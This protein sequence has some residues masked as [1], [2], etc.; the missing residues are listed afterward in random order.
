MRRVDAGDHPLSECMTAM[1]IKQA[2]LKSPDGKARP[3]FHRDTVA[4]Q[5][6]MKQIF[7]NQDYSLARL[8]RGAELQQIGRSLARPLI[9]DAGANI[10]ASVCWFAFHF[11]HAHIV[12]VEPDPAN[13]DLLRRNTEGLN[14]TPHQAALGCED[15]RV[16][17]VDPGAGEWGYRTVQASDGA[18]PL[19]AIG[20]L[21]AEQAA[22][23][24]HPF[25][26][27]V[28]IEGGE[29][30]LFAPPVDWVDRFPLIVVELHDWLMPGQGTSRNFLQC[31]ASRDRDFVYIGE[32]IFSIRNGPAA[33]E[34]ASASRMKTS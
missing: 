24:F 8:R 11:P 28:D 19:I 20:R 30:A 16:H 27:K 23:G 21:V 2:T 14:V 1:D 5:G 13:F 9:I 15:G 7:T 4:D 10:G 18:V 31:V 3:F 32:N 34:A 6:V 12:A 22:A 33:A 25:I 17:L 26:A 29:A